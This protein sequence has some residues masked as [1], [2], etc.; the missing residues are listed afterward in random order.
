MSQGGVVFQNQMINGDK[1]LCE[2]SARKKARLKL[3]ASEGRV[4]HRATARMVAVLV[5]QLHS[6]PAEV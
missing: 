1:E 5:L 2:F 3:L 4:P 6:S